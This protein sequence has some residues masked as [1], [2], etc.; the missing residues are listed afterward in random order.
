VYE[1]LSKEEYVP[2]LLTNAC[3]L[4]SKSFLQAEKDRLGHAAGGEACRKAGHLRTKTTTL[5]YMS[6]LCF[7]LYIINDVLAQNIQP[8]SFINHRE[9]ELL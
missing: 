5:N 3:I 9:C 1:K 7:E 8:Y 6:M 4:T 2:Y